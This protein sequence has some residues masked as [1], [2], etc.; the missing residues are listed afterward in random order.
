MQQLPKENIPPKKASIE[1]IKT[2][3]LKAN[4]NYFTPLNIGSEEMPEDEIVHPVETQEKNSKIGTII[5]KS[6]TCFSMANVEEIKV[7]W[8]SFAKMKHRNYL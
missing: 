2:P 1:Q 8:N 6:Q 3:K 7:K 4:F 5:L